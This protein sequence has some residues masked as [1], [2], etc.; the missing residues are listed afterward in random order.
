MP[1]TPEEQKE[2]ETRFQYHSPRGDQPQ[3]YTTIRAYAAGIAA[4]I[5]ELC[6]TSRERSLALTHLDE[7]VMFA[8]ASIARRDP[9]EVSPAP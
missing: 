6:P 1:L 4:I 8:N 3:R 7:V 2:L 5:M 9:P